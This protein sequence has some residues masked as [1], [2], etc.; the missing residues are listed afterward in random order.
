MARNVFYKRA[1]V[2]LLVCFMVCAEA[3]A[4]EGDTPPQIYDVGIVVYD[5]LLFQEAGTTATYE[6]TVRN[7]GVMDLSDVRLGMERLEEEWFSSDDTAMLESGQEANLTYTLQ[8]P[9]DSEGTHAFS[10]VVFASSGRTGISSMEIVSLNIG[11]GTTATTTT[12]TLPPTTE[13]THFLSEPAEIPESSGQ[14]DANLI[15]VAAMIVMGYVVV[16]KIL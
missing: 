5:D 12:T 1:A 3:G 9:E 15:I 6:V 7:T 4:V 14:I 13:T 8:M 16:K 10:L 2:T 11:H